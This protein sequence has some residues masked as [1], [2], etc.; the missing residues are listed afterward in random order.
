MNAAKPTVPDGAV[1]SAVH[2]ASDSASDGVG[3][4]LS[5]IIVNWNVWDLLRSC[6]LSI[7]RASRALPDETAALREFGPH[8]PPSTLELIVVDNASTDATVDFLLARFPWVRLIANKRNLGFT[9]GNNLGYAAS[10]GRFVFFLNPDTE[11]IAD[12]LGNN[13]LWDLYSSLAVADADELIALVGPRLRYG[14][15]VWQNNRRTFPTRLTGFFESTRISNTLPYNPWI[16]KYYMA[17]WVSDVGH[18]V[19]WIVGAAILAR[20]SALEQVLLPMVQGPFDESF[21]MYSEE[22][23]LCHRL[24]NA[25]WRI[26]YRPQ[27]LMIHYEGRSSEQEVAVRHINF[28]SSKVR[29]YQKYFGNRWAW[30]LRQYLLMEF[31]YGLVLEW[32]KSVLGRKREI[33]RQRVTAFRHVLASKLMPQSAASMK[34]PGMDNS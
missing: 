7:E 19:D 12:E 27:A 2:S 9:A 22:I 10:N 5:I 8:D 16:R 17:N 4:D 14:D 25:G 31:R 29:Y 23:D 6:I 13:S 32:L 21:F 11:V 1:H 3:V 30:L 18:D 20:R 28:N 15:G 34:Y 24:K 33:H 26:A